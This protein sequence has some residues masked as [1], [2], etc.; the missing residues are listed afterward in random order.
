M[1]GSFNIGSISKRCSSTHFLSLSKLKNQRM[2]LK[3]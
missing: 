2:H 1:K 3:F